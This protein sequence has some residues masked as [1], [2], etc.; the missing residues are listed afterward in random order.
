M[1]RCEQAAGRVC[2]QAGPPRLAGV[3]GIVRRPLT[4][5][6]EH[7][8][9]VGQRRIT[10]FDRGV[11]RLVAHEIDHLEGVLYLERIPNDRLIPV[12]R[13]PGSGSSWFYGSH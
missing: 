13:Y 10:I 1:C 6:V 8:D 3:R 4:I 11:A 5:H 7:Q 12:D 9:V 2:R